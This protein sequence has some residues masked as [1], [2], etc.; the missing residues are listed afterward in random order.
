MSLLAYV[1]YR[2]YKSLLRDEFQRNRIPV[3]KKIEFI[4]QIFE[5]ATEAATVPA[6]LQVILSSEKFQTLI[7]H[8]FQLKY[9][10]TLMSSCN[11]MEK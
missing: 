10:Y 5:A 4:K 9:T 3:E 7:K 6:S 2:F 11:I 1:F 8:A